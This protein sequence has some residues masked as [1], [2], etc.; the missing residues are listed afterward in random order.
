MIINLNKEIIRKYILVSVYAFIYPCLLSAQTVLIRIS[1]NT[2]EFTK[3]KNAQILIA[4]SRLTRVGVRK[5]SV[6]LK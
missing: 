6:L 4:L 5:N 1:T 2:P 3:H